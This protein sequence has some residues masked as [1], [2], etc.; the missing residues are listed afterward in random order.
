[1]EPVT[2]QF[3]NVREEREQELRDDKGGKT[4]LLRADFSYTKETQDNSVKTAGENKTKIQLISVYAP[5]GLGIL[6]LILVIV[7]PLM[8]RRPRQYPAEHR[9]E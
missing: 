5:I 9:H 2:G 6:G 1:M 8:M 4:T 7:G 3:L